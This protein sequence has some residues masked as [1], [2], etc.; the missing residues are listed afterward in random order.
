MIH[1]PECRGLKMIDLCSFNKSLK[2]LNVAKLELKLNIPFQVC[3]NFLD[4]CQTS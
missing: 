1:E 3:N 2:V 4:T